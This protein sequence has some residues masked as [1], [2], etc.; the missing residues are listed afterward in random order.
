MRAAVLALAVA[1]APVLPP[2]PAPAQTAVFTPPPV[3]TEWTYRKEFRAERGRR[4][5]DALWNGMPLLTWLRREPEGRFRDHFRTD[6][7]AWVVTLADDGTP[8]AGA[9]PDNGALDWPLAVGKRWQ[10]EFRAE[11]WNPRRSV[12]TRID[13]TVEAEETHE[14]PFGP[15]TAFRL[16]GVSPGTV[17]TNWFAPAL[18]VYLRQRVEE[19][20]R[21]TL[22]RELVEYRLPAQ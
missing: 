14:T 21:V 15:V 19:G 9:S 20:G 16:R 17:R 22:D 8:V 4:L 3:G 1:L 11:S 2:M 5:P 10:A 6:T 12:P 7:G 13:W 18:G